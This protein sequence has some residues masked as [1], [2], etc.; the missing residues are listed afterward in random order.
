MKE[1]LDVLIEDYN[2]GLTVRQIAEKY[3][4]KYDYVRM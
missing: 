1:K 2:L 4:Q 3:N